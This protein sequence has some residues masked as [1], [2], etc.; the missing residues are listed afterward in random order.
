MTNDVAGNAQIE[1]ER[2]ESQDSKKRKTNPPIDVSV[3]HMGSYKRA[4]EAKV[5]I[6]KAAAQWTSPNVQPSPK[7]ETRNP[8]QIRMT[9]DD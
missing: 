2:R 9:T 4:P 3:C 1:P 6:G 5:K 7:P 8:S